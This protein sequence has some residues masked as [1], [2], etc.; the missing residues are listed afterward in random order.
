[1]STAR[2]TLSALR[3]NVMIYTRLQ[4]W[5]RCRW[6]I[7]AFLAL[8]GLSQ[9]GAGADLHLEHHQRLV[10]QWRSWGGTAPTSSTMTVLQFGDNGSVPYNATDDFNATN[11]GAG[12]FSVQELDFGNTATGSS[13][14]TIGQTSSSTGIVL[15][16]TTTNAGVFATGSGSVNIAANLTIA[17]TFSGTTIGNVGAGTLTIAGTLTNQSTTNAISVGGSGLTVISGAI[18]GT[19]GLGTSGTTTLNLTGSN[20]G[21]TGA[22]TINTGTTVG[23]SN[24]NSLGA[25]ANTVALTVRSRAC[26][27]RRYAQVITSTSGTLNAAAGTTLTISTAVGGTTAHDWRGRPG[28][29]RCGLDGHGA[30]HRCGRPVAKRDQ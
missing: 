10:V 4:Y 26:K 14:V 9:S 6:A 1:M 30:D 24:A 20:T 22:I 7:L 5:A 23:V 2:N 15:A 11:G 12:G 18:S 28:Q 21:L 3:G 25:A 16:G 17:S 27:T 13:L 19:T 29:P 8:L